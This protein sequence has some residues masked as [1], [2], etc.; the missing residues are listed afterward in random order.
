MLLIRNPWGRNPWDLQPPLWYTHSMKP[1]PD[2][3]WPIRPLDWS[4]MSPRWDTKGGAFVKR[5]LNWNPALDGATGKF[6]MTLED[7][8]HRYAAIFICRLPSSFRITK[9]DHWS[10]SKI[11]QRSGGVLTCPTGHQNTQ[12]KIEVKRSVPL[13]ITLTQETNTFENLKYIMVAMVPNG[14]KGIFKPLVQEDMEM[15][16]FHFSGKPIRQLQVSMDLDLVQPGWYTIVVCAFDPGST[17]DFCL[18]VYS[19]VENC[20][21]ELVRL[22]D[23]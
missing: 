1:N 11:N 9:R 5:L 13:F 7:F 2:Q 6:W 10:F 20:L 18:C 15:D 17:I 21:S 16:G 22:Y 12:W 19:T 23:E 4:P 3:P 14:G 8:L